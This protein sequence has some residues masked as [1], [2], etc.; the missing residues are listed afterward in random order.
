MGRAGN[1]VPYWPALKGQEHYSLGLQPQV[2]RYP[3]PCK[4]GCK[5][6]KLYERTLRARLTALPGVLGGPVYLGLQPQAIMF[7]GLQPW[8]GPRW[9]GALP[10][11]RERRGI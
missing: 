2:T 3:K 11:F 9:L 1:G 7:Q 8:H 6:C 5:P 10:A 4:Q